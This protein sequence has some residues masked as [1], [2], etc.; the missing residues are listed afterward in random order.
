MVLTNDRLIILTEEGVN[1]PFLVIKFSRKT[2]DYIIYIKKFINQNQPNEQ[3][4][5]SHKE[6]VDIPSYKVLKRLLHPA[7]T[8]I[9]NEPASSCWSCLQHILCNA[10][11]P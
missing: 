9:I 2:R 10:T 6:I 3:I 8:L 5:T 4:S 11:S 1:F 7:Q